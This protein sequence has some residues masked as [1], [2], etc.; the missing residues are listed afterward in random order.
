MAEACV[1]YGI[2]GG[3]LLY[4]GVFFFCMAETHTYYVFFP[5]CILLSSNF[6]EMD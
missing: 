1:L 5:T 6:L 3:S 4:G 2:Q